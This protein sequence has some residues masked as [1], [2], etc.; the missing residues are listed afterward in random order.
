MDAKLLQGLQGIKPLF[1]SQKMEQ[2]APCNE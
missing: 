1:L 2:N